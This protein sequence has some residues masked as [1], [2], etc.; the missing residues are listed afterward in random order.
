MTAVE[1]VENLIKLGTVINDAVQK[2]GSSKSD[3]LTFLQSPAFAA[4]ESSVTQLLGSLKKTDVP[5]AIQALDQKQT[6]LL[7][8]KSLADLPTDKL[9]QYA[10]LGNV[11][12]VLAAGEVADAMNPKF[13]SWLVDSALPVLVKAAPIVLPLLL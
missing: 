9:L 12:V 5:Q 13:A 10:E 11:K 1:T 2:S 4:I 3:W 6:A 7:G 8:G